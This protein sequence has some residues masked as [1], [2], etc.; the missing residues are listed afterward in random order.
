MNKKVISLPLYENIKIDVIISWII[1]ALMVISSVFSLVMRDEIYTTDD[2]AQAFIANDIVNLAIGV[3][4]L[5]LAIYLIKKQNLVGLL[6]WP[7]ALFYILYNYLVYVL[8][9]PFSIAFIFNTLIILLSLLVLIRFLTK[10]NREAVKA[11][12][13]MDIPNKWISA[14]MILM[15]VAFFLMAAS[16]ILQFIFGQLQLTTPEIALNISDMTFSLVWV[17]CG[18]SFWRRRSLGYLTSLGL[19]YQLSM[20]FLGLIVVFLI[21]P[22]IFNSPLATFD[23]IILA[24]MSLIA[25]IPFWLFLKALKSRV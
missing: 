12:I 13:G 16:K 18:I 8:S 19:L 25:V 7:G 14:S 4:V 9:L 2:L 6:L 22:L 15:G 24:L 3:P 1:A 23:L 20:L 5:I 17:G 11:Q 21:Q 10:I